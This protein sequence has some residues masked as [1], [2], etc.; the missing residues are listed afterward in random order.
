MKLKTALKSFVL[1]GLLF[2][3]SLL[4]GLSHAAEPVA[5]QEDPNQQYIT[6]LT[7]KLS[8]EAREI[9]APVEVGVLRVFFSVRSTGDFKLELISPS[10]RAVP[11]SEPNILVTETDGK[12]TIAMWDPRPGLWKMRLI[13]SGDFTAAAWAQGELYICCMQF[14]ARNLIHQLDKFQPVRGSRQQAQ[15]YASGFNIEAMEFQVISEQGELI[16]PLK[17]RQSDFSNPYNF[18]L[19]LETPDQPFRI[20][21][22]GRDLNGKQFQRVF[23]SLVRPVSAEAANTQPDVPGTPV[24]PLTQDWDK[25]AVAGEYKIVRAQ[26]TNW[27]DEPLLSEKGNPIGV[28]LKYS[29]RFP[30]DGQYSPYPQAFPERITNTYTG[31]LSLRLH[32]SQVEPLPDG[33][34]TSQQMFFSGRPIFKA[35]ITYNFTVEMVPGYAI[36][37]EQK[38]NFCLQTR[39]Y[40]QQGIRERFERE[41]TSEAKVRFRL[42]FSGTD[43]ESRTPVLTENAYAP[44]AWHRSFTKDG[45]VECQ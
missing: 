24:A 40:S 32:R 31:A 12:K 22:R 13:G 2:C 41:V 9:E 44:G 20:R 16:A 39:S 38:K 34:Q 35:G 33:L 18:T 27:S 7:G 30:V 19:L 25:N 26:I 5:I 21:A 17:I 37:N 45:V 29:I 43:L 28:R 23:Y 4:T 15:V 36:Y 1:V 6:I 42:S 14:F 3:Q 10:G 8:G 11:L